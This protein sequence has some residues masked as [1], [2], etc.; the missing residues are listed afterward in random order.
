VIDTLILL[1]LLVVSLV[2][3]WKVVVGNRFSLVK[4]RYAITL[5]DGEGEFVGLL[6]ERRWARLTFDE[7]VIPPKSN[8]EA[9]QQVPGLLH[10]ERV[11]IAY[12][13]ELPNDTV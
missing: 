9:P 13:Q 2:I 7:C 8:S 5:K 4:K 10:V 6:I 3:M 12:L 11:N 1:A